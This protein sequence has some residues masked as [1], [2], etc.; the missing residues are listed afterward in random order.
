MEVLLPKNIHTLSGECYVC[1]QLPTASYNFSLLTLLGRS[2]K[3]NTELDVNLYYSR[4]KLSERWNVFPHY[5][6]KQQ[7]E[8]SRVEPTG[9]KATS[10]ICQ[11]FMLEEMLVQCFV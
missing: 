2:F 6:I 10:T 4:R 11:M 8:M 1:F 3:A 5:A 9:K 7:F